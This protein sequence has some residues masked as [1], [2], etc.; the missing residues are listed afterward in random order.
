MKSNCVARGYAL[1]VLAAA[2]T[3]TLAQSVYTTPY[4]FTNFAGLPGLRGTNDGTSSAARFDHAGGACRAL[5]LH[6][7]HRLIS[8]LY[9]ISKGAF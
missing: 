8:R 7:L 6:W 3:Q 5:P 2:A 1:L 9:H 4:A